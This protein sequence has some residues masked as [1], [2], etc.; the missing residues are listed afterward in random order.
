MV[1][2]A[3]NG[4][5][6]FWFIAEF[7][8]QVSSGVAP[9]RTRVSALS[10]RERTSHSVGFLVETGS[11]CRRIRLEESS[12]THGSP[13]D[14]KRILDSKKLCVTKQ[15]PGWNSTGIR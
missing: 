6:C 10:D 8:D 2:M 15:G 9:N 14:L 3:R 7:R 1:F 5:V 13:R 12:G 4:R 11:R